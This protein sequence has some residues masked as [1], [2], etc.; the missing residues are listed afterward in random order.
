MP[1]A[2]CTKCRVRYVWD[3]KR[4]LVR[5]AVCPKDGSKL[6]PTSQNVLLPVVN[7]DAP[8]YRKKRT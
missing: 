5:E 4:H 7:I 2:K 6:R 3:S 8:V 1:Q